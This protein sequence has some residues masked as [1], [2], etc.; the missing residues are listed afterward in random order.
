MSLRELTDFLLSG[1]QALG[2][3]RRKINQP[4]HADLVAARG[5]P[6][7][8]QKPVVASTDPVSA[9]ERRAGACRSGAD[10]LAI[11]SA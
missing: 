1:D 5:S 9:R 8:V 3:P 11:R 10:W 6:E 2:L 7:V 4:T